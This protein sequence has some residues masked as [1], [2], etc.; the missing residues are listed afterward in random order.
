MTEFGYTKKLE[1]HD[2]VKHQ[3]NP[4]QQHPFY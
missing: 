2:P 1:I 3:T 4:P